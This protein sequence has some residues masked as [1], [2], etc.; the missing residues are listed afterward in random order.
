[1]QP[2]QPDMLV[3]CICAKDRHLTAAQAGRRWM[4][5]L[6][7]G[8]IDSLIRIKGLT[9]SG[10]HRVLQSLSRRKGLRMKTAASLFAGTMLLF[11]LASPAAAQPAN[12]EHGHELAQR[13]CVN[14]HV[15]DKNPS[16]P[17]RTDVPSFATIAARPGASAEKIAGAIIIPHPA[18]P[19][20]QL[21][22]AEIRDIVAYILSLKSQK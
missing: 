14:C 11:L 1:M 4:S 22:V 19:G 3:S 7:A 9:A 2:D 10:H 5:A 18:M 13:L 15:V 16:G 20:V 17:L 8:P 6:L 12:P 21:T